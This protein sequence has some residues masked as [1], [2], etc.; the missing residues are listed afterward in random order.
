MIGLI[1]LAGQGGYNMISAAQKSGSGPHR[2]IMQQLTDSKWVP[3]KSL[4][5]QQYEEMLMQKLLKIDV[6]VSLIDEK[7]ANL[8]AANVDVSNDDDPS[9]G[10]SAA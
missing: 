7:I 4:S 9:N 6:E 1:S 8:E 3:L 2:S 10:I 5:D